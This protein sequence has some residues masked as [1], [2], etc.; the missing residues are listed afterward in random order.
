MK[1]GPFRLPAPVVI[2]AVALLMGAGPASAQRAQKPKP[3]PQGKATQT[4]PRPT[5]DPVAALIS[6]SEQHFANGER[7]LKL[8]HLDQARAEFDRAVDVLL[9]S[10]YGARWDARLREH[11]DRLVDRINAYEVTALA[12]GDGFTEKKYETA[13]LDELLDIATFVIKPVAVPDTRESVQADLEQRVSDVPIPMNEKVL[14][15]VELFQGRLR[16]FIQ[17]GLQ[18]GTKYLPMI[19]NVFRAEGLPLDLAYIPIVESAFK[20]NALSRAKAK[21]VWQFMRGTALENGLRHDWYIDERSDP[22]KATLAAAKYLKTLNG[23]FEGDWHL[24]LAS[25]NG[26]PGRV[27]RALKRYRADDFWSLIERGRRTLPRETREYVPMILAAM[28]IARN[29]SQYGFE[30][31]AEPPIE[32][33]KV[34]VPKAVD[35]RRVAEWTG[36]SIDTIQSLNPELRRWTTPVRYEYEVK[37]PVGSAEGLRAKLEDASAAELTAVKWYT[38]RRGETLRSIARK[39]KVNRTDLAE[40]NQLRVSSRVRTGQSLIIPRAPTTLLAA[41]SDRPSPPALAASR[42]IAEAADDAPA[43]ASATNSQQLARRTYRVRRG[44]TLSS[45]ARLFN[46]TVAKIKNWNRLNS[47]RITAGDRLTIFASASR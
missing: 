44:D 18:R 15:Y 10:Q 13:S 23:M 24:A 14:S 45:I 19:Q 9:E 42:T 11:F 2:G 43:R 31:T 46:T 34:R 8:G 39:L 36:S 28:I 12:Q 5:P 27:Q 47:N 4:Q 38:V 25:Y 41:R 1:R 26:G 17:E 3:A 40:A 32:Y 16:D 21:G 29:P 22:E 6:T 20:P 37:V 7:E 30:I 35:L 33:E